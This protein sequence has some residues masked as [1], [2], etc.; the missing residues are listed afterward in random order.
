MNNKVRNNYCT[1][2]EELIRCFKNCIEREG[3]KLGYLNLSLKSTR[4]EILKNIPENMSERYYLDKNYEKILND[5]LKM[6]KND[7]STVFTISPISDTENIKKQKIQEIKNFIF[8]LIVLLAYLFMFGCIPFLFFYGYFT[9][10][11]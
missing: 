9:I 3:V 10:A 5:V 11:K 2:S 4:N 8:N 1:V 6:Y 7:N